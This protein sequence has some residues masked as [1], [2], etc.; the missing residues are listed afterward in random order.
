MPITCTV[1]LACPP[2]IR[3]QYVV[4][5]TSPVMFR[6]PA[7]LSPDPFVVS[8]P[9][10]PWYIWKPPDP[11]VFTSTAWST[12]GTY[13]YQTLA[14]AVVDGS[15]AWMLPPEVRHG[16]PADAS[17]AASR[18]GSRDTRW[19]VDLLRGSPDPGWQRFARLCAIR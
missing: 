9:R 5:A 2:V 16:V 19:V 1:P 13:R 10:L 14:H 12:D 15:P 6:V 7:L 8:D 17:P 3:I 4:P 11:V 18:L